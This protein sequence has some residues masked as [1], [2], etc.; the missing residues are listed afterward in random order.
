[1]PTLCNNSDTGK[2]GGVFRLPVSFLDFVQKKRKK[3]KKK[4]K[5]EIGEKLK[6]QLN[7]LLFRKTEI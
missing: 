4:K 5:K 3:E 6:M 7:L 2:P 1:M